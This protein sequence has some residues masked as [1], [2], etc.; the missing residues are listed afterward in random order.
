LVLVDE[1]SAQ[2]TPIGNVASFVAGLTYDPSNHILFGIRYDTTSRVPGNIWELVAID[3]STGNTTVVGDTGIDAYYEYPGGLALDPADG[4]LYAVGQ[5]GSFYSVDKANGTA[6][7][8]GDVGF[9]QNPTSLDFDPTSGILYAA[10]NNPLFSTGQLITIDPATGTGALVAAT[11]K[12]DA[13]AFDRAGTLYATYTRRGGKP[14]PP[15][16]PPPD[17][18][19]GPRPL[20]FTINK[21]TG[22]WTPVAHADFSGRIGGLDFEE[23][24]TVQ[25]EIDIKPDSY[26]NSLNPYSRGV[27]P[28]VILGS[29]TFDAADV[30]V[31]TLAFGPGAAPT[32]HN[33]TDSFTHNDHL[34]DVNLD[35]LTD[36]VTHYWTR[37]TG[38]ACGDESVALTGETIDGQPFEGSDSIQT[39]GCRVRRWPA[40]WM[41]DEE[42][43]SEPRGGIVNLERR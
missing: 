34:Q 37:D 32:A 27:I 30:D 20:L 13:I 9:F 17:C 12:A 5:A 15:T 14:P 31:T 26:P 18:G 1:I 3:P 10:T 6:T 38:I 36:L 42:R 33:L 24:R 40:I 2:L 23:T 35:G 41:K 29:D 8:I 11:G 21:E 19:D 7:F 22:V 43:A 4:R 39:V 25:V 16:E 28:V